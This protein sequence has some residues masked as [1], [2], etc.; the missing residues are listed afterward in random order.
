MA[1]A[2]ETEKDHARRHGVNG[3]TYA[4]W[5]LRRHGY[6]FVARNYRVAGDKAEI[7]LVGYDGSVL[8]F[9][10][11]KTRSG[12]DERPGQPEEAVTADKRVHVER[13][14]RRFLAERRTPGVSWRF[15]VVAIESRSGR[16][17][18]VRLYKNAF[19]AT[20]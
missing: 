2:D 17:P 9:V 1:K 6:V 5:Y 18:D 8:A 20:H 15:D 13:M 19:G 14:A 12:T 10:E 7:D 3:E 11:V 16:P 4:Y